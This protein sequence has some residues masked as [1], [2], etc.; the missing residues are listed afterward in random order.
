[1][2]IQH[3]NDERKGTFY[4]EKEGSRVAELTYSKQDGQKFIINHTEVS[5]ELRG[6]GVGEQLVMAAVDYARENNMKILPLCSF[7]KTIFE[8][9]ESIRDVLSDDEI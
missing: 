3:K 6:K 7:T 8:K 9:N 1:M 5:D 2:N 4:I